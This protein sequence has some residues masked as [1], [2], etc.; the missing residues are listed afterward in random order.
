[1][2]TSAGTRNSSAN[3]KSCESRFSISTSTRRVD[4]HCCNALLIMLLD[5]S[6][7]RPLPRLSVPI[8]TTL[9]AHNHDSMC[10][11]RWPYVPVP[12]APC[13]SFVALRNFFF[14]FVCSF[15]KDRAA[16][17]VS[18]LQHV[19]VSQTSTV[20]LHS[21]CPCSPGS[22]SQHTQC[23]CI[24]LFQN[25]LF[26]LPMQPAAPCSPPPKALTRPV[27]QACGQASWTA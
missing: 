18:V 8:S 26:A 3:G 7:R 24:C 17:F 23:A 11:F 14:N 10:S 21:V 5:C 6:C 20:A 16:D 19:P 1:M 2:G 15:L 4:D 22:P 12:T 13:A 25:L 9:C 27:R